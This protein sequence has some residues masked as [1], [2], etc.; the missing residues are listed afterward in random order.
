MKI[1]FIHGLESKGPSP[2]KVNF[3]KT[4]SDVLAPTINWKSESPDKIWNNL[5][6]QI[7]KFKPDMLIGSSMGGYAAYCLG[8]HLK[9]NT[10]LFNPPIHHR[11]I[12]MNF[13]FNQNFIKHRIFFG[14]TDTVVDRDL[15]IKELINHQANFTSD[16]YNGGHQVK[17]DVFKKSISKIMKIKES[18]ICSFQEFVNEQ[19]QTQ[20]ELNEGVMSNLHL[21]AKNVKSEE[22]FV[23]EF[24]K[25]YGDKIKQT[26][27]S[28]EW[29]RSLYRDTKK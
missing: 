5:I 16:I 13:K 2:E 27:N 11:S 3:L 19:Y 4:I 14:S 24:F 1:F 26:S 8:E 6:N 20:I 15:V 21:I 10:I 28:Y 9:I 12:D 7:I 22:E 29:V 18:K 23:K 17:L 25:Q